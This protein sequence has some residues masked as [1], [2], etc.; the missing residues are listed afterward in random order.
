[1]TYTQACEARDRALSAYQSAIDAAP[2]HCKGALVRD[3]AALER[4]YRD[5]IS[6][7]FPAST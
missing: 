4:D 2:E 6:G 7:N 3:M 5:W 1:M